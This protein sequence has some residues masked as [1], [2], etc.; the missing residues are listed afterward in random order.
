MEKKNRTRLDLRTAL[1]LEMPLPELNFILPGLLGG[2]VG[3]ITA[4]G[5][6][7]KTF[8]MIQTAISLAS[9]S[10]KIP[11]FG[12]AWDAPSFRGRV[13][14]LLA[15]DPLEILAHR[16]RAI[17]KWLSAS[18][19]LQQ[20]TDD[21]EENLEIHSLIGYQPC[22][23]D[24]QGKPDQKWLDM[25]KRAAEG[26]MLLGIDPLRRWHQGNEIDNGVMMY[27]VQLLESVSKETGCT[28]LVAH[29]VNKLAM[30]SGNGGEQG[31][32]RGASALT[33]G[34]RW[35]LNLSK[36]AKEEVGK[37]G[38]DENMRGNYVKMEISKSN[39]GSPQEAVWLRREEGGILTKAVLNQVT[40]RKSR[41]ETK[42]DQQWE[43]CPE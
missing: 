19:S 10:Q 13:A 40:S 8:W 20:L 41:K 22:L 33:D 36:M 26:T 39:Y 17:G 5:G 23:L 42:H 32:A 11:F 31:A 14:L 38:L 2:T 21:L 37:Y 35:Q 18:Y 29:H 12:G 24:T 15:E 27:L 4:P 1:D 30:F 25:L 34:V 6:T 9:Y 28:I 7:G 3:M 43:Q 16:V